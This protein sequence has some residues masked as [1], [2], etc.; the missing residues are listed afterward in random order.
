VRRSGARRPFRLS[1][2][3]ATVHQAGGAGG[4]KQRKKALIEMRVVLE[5]LKS[6]GMP[7][8]SRRP[9]NWF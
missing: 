3:V 8:A 2:G 9:P 7:P 6:T 1:R 4:A 5:S